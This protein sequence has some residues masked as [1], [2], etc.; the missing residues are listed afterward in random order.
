MELRR[1]GT[2]GLHVSSLGLGTLTWGRDTDDH[3][4][5]E[6]LDLFLEAGG[7]LIDTGATYAD[8]DAEQLIGQLVGER[9]VRDDVVLVS[10][11]GVCPAGPGRGHPDAGRASLLAS[12]E[13]SLT[14]LGT[15][16]LDLW[17]VSQHDAQVNPAEMLSA[18]SWAVSSGK[19][20]YVGL[21][22][23]PAWA[24]AE[25]HALLGAGPLSSGN[26]LAGQGLAAV[27]MEYSLLQRG[28]E[29]EVLPLTQSRGIGVLAWSP[30]ARG[31][32]AGRYRSSIPANSRAA[33]PHL[34]GFVEPYL[35]DEAHGIVEA[36]AAAAEG[37]NCQVLDVALAWVR[38]HPGISCAITG[39]RTAAQLRGILSGAKTVIP[40][41][42]REALDEVTAISCGYPE[43][44]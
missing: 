32:L 26:P 29:R 7:N 44:F 22:N 12:L 6:Q 19:V 16:Y 14:R 1:L 39:A 4:A 15:D 43:R 3:E 36:V 13:G 33:S 37:M 27:E 34:S 35:S 31:V 21:S 41:Q 5:G 11:A 9:G 24:I 23:F 38:H 40:A 20:R 42:I 2:T 28:I 8:G 17:L 10:K 18:L 30:L 25:A